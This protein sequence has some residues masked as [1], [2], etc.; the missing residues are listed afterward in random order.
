MSTTT[1]YELL[2][3]LRAR[4]RKSSRHKKKLILDEFCSICEYNRKYAIR[5]FNSEVSV[6]S[7][8]NLK[9]RGRKKVYDDPLITEVL[10]DIWV[11]NNLPCSKRL[12]AILPLWLPFYDKRSVPEDIKHKLLKISAATMDR[13]FRPQ[14]ARFGKLG[15]STTKPGSLIKKKIPIKTVQWD[16]T[17]PGFLEADT[18]A[19]CGRSVA[20]MY[21]YT[22]NTVDIASQWTEQ[23]ATWGKGESGVVAAIKNIENTLPFKLKGFDCDN[24]S[25]FLNWHLIRYLTQK[26]KKPVQLTRARS[27]QK[28]DNAHIENKNW[29][30]IRQYL[31]FQRFDKPQLVDMLNDLYT[32]EWNAYFNFFNPSMKLVN[33]KRIGSKIIKQYDAPKTPFQRL[34]ESRHLDDQTKQRLQKQFLSLNPFEIQQRMKQKIDTII[35]V[36]NQS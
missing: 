24:G 15:L 10:R 17:I 22:L 5:L 2:Q 32:T 31:G 4:Y 8:Q 19:H 6:R 35:N 23:R 11:A 9:K 34:M 1:K 21:V 27:Y 28:N 12:K 16:E 20:G 7:L 33:K 13:L 29:T 18:V 14:R 30:H 3:A 25:E 36:V 26:R